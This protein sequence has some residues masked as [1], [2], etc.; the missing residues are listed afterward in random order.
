MQNPREENTWSGNGTGL[1]GP[2][3]AGRPVFPDTTPAIFE[4]IN[5]EQH[6][7]DLDE[8]CEGSSEYALKVKTYLITIQD[9]C[10]C[11]LAH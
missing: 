3:I 11:S 6:V 4:R 1:G 7:S 9:C 8:I 5:D 2:I 10:C